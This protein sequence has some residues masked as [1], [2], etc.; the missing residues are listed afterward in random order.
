MEDIVDWALWGKDSYWEEKVAGCFCLLGLVIFKSLAFIKWVLGE[1]LNEDLVQGPHF[2]A[3]MHLDVCWIFSIKMLSCDGYWT[4]HAKKHH[5][6]IKPS[7]WMATKDEVCN[8]EIYEATD[9][10][11]TDQAETA[12][13]RPPLVFS[14]IMGRCWNPE[15]WVRISQLLCHHL[16]LRSKIGIKQ[17]WVAEMMNK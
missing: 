8:Q 11:V 17:G 12:S 4:W 15:Q 13:I 6:Q 1:F 16:R 10:Q 14:P 5:P 9:V 7:G 2:I 3:C